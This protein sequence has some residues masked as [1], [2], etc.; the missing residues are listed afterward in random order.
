M[1]DAIEVLAVEVEAEG[2]EAGKRIQQK[3]TPLGVFFY[4]PIFISLS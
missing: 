1:A 3:N 2:K 4:V